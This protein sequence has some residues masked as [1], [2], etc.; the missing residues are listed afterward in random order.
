MT[1]RAP[2]AANV[3]APP[4]MFSTGGFGGWKWISSW[5]VRDDGGEGG[6]VMEEECTND[7]HA[8]CAEVYC[9][10]FVLGTRK[11]CCWTGHILYWKN[12]YK[13]RS[14]DWLYGREHIR[15]Q[16]PGWM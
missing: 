9:L 1:I 12:V 3:P 2:R 16:S 4:R 5:C 15:R 11:Y 7:E 6:R 13:R 8:E 14:Y 10:D